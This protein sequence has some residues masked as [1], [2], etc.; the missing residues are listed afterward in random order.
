M[1]LLYVLLIGEASPRPKVL[2]ILTDVAHPLSLALG[3]ALVRVVTPR[4]LL[5][6]VGN[7]RNLPPLLAGGTRVDVL[8]DD[9]SR[10]ASISQRYKSEAGLR[11]VTGEYDAPL[12]FAERF[13]GALSTHALLHGDRNR[14]RTALNNVFAA[15]NDGTPLYVV[16][17]SRSD[18]RYGHG[19]RI[20]DGVF[21]PDDGPE[22]GVAHVFFDEAGVRDV[23]GGFVLIGLEETS[24][25]QSAG[26]WAHATE[27]A[28]GIV[29]WFVRAAKPAAPTTPAG[30]GGY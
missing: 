2:Y 17:G 30:G 4:I 15:L 28:A 6:G 19:R 16:L 8:D 1:H 13:D 5:L 7:G 27:E 11:I 21:A 18:P 23:L 20:E 14:V 25:A 29:H 9:P 24:A 3:E 12:P 22:A 26:R 10:T